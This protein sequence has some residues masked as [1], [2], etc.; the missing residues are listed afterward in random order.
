MPRFTDGNPG[1]DQ[2]HRRWW[3]SR[4]EKE[5]NKV[6]A[7]MDEKP[8]VSFDD[9]KPIQ[10]GQTAIWTYNNGLMLARVQLYFEREQ[11]STFVPTNP[12][13]QVALPASKVPAKTPV[14]S[15]KTK[16]TRVASR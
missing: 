1:N 13:R 12:V 4:L 11:K 6:T 9:S 7:Y 15:A 5:G 2:V 10:G 3:Y 16:L 8:I 14:R